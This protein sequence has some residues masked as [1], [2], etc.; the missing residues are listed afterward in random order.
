ML[1]ISFADLSGWDRDDHAAGL[2]A[3]LRGAKHAREGLGVT[4][5]DWLRAAQGGRE[6]LK[7]GRARDFFEAH[8]TPVVIEDGKKPLF[9]GYYEPELP[10]SL[11]PDARYRFPIYRMPGPGPMPTRAEVMAG[12]LSGKGLEIAWLEDEAEAYFLQ[13][14][15]SGRLRL[16]DGRAM[17]I[18][19]AG[20]NGQ[21]YVS[22]GGI[23]RREGPKL[24]GGL[25]AQ[26]I[27]A[28]I[29]ANPEA[30][31]ALM[32]RNP[33]FIFFREA[34]GLRPED[35]PAG[36]MGVPLT[37]LRSVAV[38]PKKAPLGAPVWIETRGPHGP[39]EALFA[40]QDT[41]GAILGAQRADLF[42][43]T[44]AEAGK[45]AGRMHAEGRLV[46][47]LPRAAVALGG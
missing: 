27:K 12:A 6:A 22:I 45:L 41:G 17:R 15:G 3:F 32:A 46:T 35:G 4:A 1:P 42:F 30:G 14:Q 25:S 19:F 29:R 5:E 44:G 21:D 26:S 23:L 40:A 33:R 28:W 36:A 39:I 10:A 31:R 16:A 34:K 9:T 47:L 8:F 11:T 18:G 20:M 38:D 24:P 2:S 13:V 43:G 7:A 37:P